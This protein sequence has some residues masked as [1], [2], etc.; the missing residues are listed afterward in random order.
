[1]RHRQP[2]HDLL[3][4]LRGACGGGGVLLIMQVCVSRAGVSI[5]VRAGLAAGVAAP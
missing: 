4:A 1:V 3:C 2:G 5:G